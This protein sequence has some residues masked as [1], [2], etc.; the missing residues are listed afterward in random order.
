[1]IQGYNGDYQ[2]VAANDLLIISNFYPRERERESVRMI[3][4][5]DE[6][7]VMTMNGRVKVQNGTQIVAFLM[8]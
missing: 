5:M 6:T 1:M 8:N 3:S 7:L 2:I 4:L